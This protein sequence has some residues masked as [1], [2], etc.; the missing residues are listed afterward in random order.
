MGFISNAVNE[1]LILTLLSV[2]LLAGAIGGNHTQTENQFDV[3]EYKTE[4]IGNM[5]SDVLS[6]PSDSNINAAYYNLLEEMQWSG[7]HVNEKSATYEAYLEACN[8]VLRGLSENGQA[9][10][11]EMNSLYAELV[12]S[13]HEPNEGTVKIDESMGELL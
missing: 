9:D 2:I 13:A 10:T 7:R 12:P 11:S 5:M 6:N 1:K 3:Y 4:L 8:D